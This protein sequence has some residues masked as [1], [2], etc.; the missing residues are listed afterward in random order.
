M[1]QSGPQK[2]DPARRRILEEFG[3]PA[4]ASDLFAGIV[5]AEQVNERRFR[6]TLDLTKLTVPGGSRV[7]SYPLLSGGQI[8]AGARATPSEQA[9]TRRCRRS[10]ARHNRRVEVAGITRPARNVGATVLLE[11]EPA[12]NQVTPDVLGPFRRRV[13]LRLSAICNRG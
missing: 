8:I 1:D 7:A 2:V 6:G 10:N 13:V 11:A 3:D 9:G 4:R 12:V 5:S